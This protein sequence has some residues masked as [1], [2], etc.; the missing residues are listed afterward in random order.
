[1]E[2]PVKQLIES[3]KNS[4][5]EIQK[6]NALVGF[7]GF[8]DFIQRIIK[9]RDLSSF[10]Y[11]STIEEF[12]HDVS[13]AAGKS[14]QFELLNQEV[15]LG[16]NAPIMSNAL[17]H[18]G[19]HNYCL[20]SLGYPDLHPVFK[21]LHKNVEA[22]SISEPG[23][24]NALEFDDG[25]LILSE[26]SS[27][28]LMDWPYLK[29]KSGVHL[30]EMISKSKLIAL[31]DW[32]NINHAND[33][34]KGIQTEILPKLNQAER[35]FF[36]DLCD[37]SKKSKKDLENIL[38]TISQYRF[39][40]KVVLGMNENEANKI[41]QQLFP[42]TTVTPSLAEKG[43]L[44]FQY[45]NI[46]LLLIHPVDRALGIH[47]EGIVEVQGKLVLKPKI[48]TGGG[49]NFNAGLCLGLMLNLSL[50]ESMLAGIATSGSYVSH[51]YSPDVDG[52]ISYLEAW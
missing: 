18:L 38:H 5:E 31:V 32:A 12:G 19:I 51:G 10:S 6:Y 24:T 3:L 4:R 26:L 2:A 48:S 23:M 27:F 41:Y 1:M 43:K 16:G 11:Y 47:N 49:D 28:A 37:P 20:A 35:I 15:K 13:A 46:D 17:G 44:I 25:K 14:G 8:V 45:L 39:H 34:W 21:H 40:G 52:I 36:F 7:D 33:I 29:Q 9:T 30:A 42:V 50:E 22:I